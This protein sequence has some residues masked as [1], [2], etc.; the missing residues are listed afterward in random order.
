MILDV[1][2]Q[3]IE[4]RFC[5]HKATETIIIV[6]KAYWYK[7][8]LNYDCLVLEID[9]KGKRSFCSATYIENEIELIGIQIERK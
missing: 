8:N 1:F 7:G 5:I 2:T 4:G 3:N 9:E 6:K